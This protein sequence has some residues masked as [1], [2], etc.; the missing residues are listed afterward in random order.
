MPP[1]VE[2]YLMW[3]F[4]H[5]ALRDKVW[6]PALPFGTKCGSRSVVGVG[7]GACPII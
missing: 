7:D 5:F 1:D 2:R 4:A 3:R 6:E